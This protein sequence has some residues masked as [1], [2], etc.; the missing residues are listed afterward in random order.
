MELAF[1][2]LLATFVDLFFNLDTKL[3]EWANTLGPWLYLLLF[4]IV[5]C[6]TGLVVTPFLPGDSLLFAVGALTSIE[7][8]SVRLELVIPPSREALATYLREGK[9]DLIAAGLAITPERR[10]EFAFTAP[11]NRVSELLVVSAKDRTTRS[12]ADM[13]GRKIGVRRSS[14]Y[15]QALA[16]LQ[17]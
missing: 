11:Y 1:H 13:R 7:G 10:Q 12:L 14:S 6:E 2:D 5:F 4:T 15:Y 3:A 9:G 8:S 16:P 17:A